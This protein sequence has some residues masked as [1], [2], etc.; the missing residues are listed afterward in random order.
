MGIPTLTRLGN[1]AV[2]GIVGFLPWTLPLLPALPIAWRARRDPAVRYALASS[3]VPLIVVFL[4][5]NQRRRYLRPVSR[6]LAVRGG[7]WSPPRT[8]AGPPAR[9][10]SAWAPPG[11][12]ARGG[13]VPRGR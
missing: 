10:V 9:R 5:E 6:A 1:S 8:G 13:A 12:A 2:D 11:P 3:I 7:W 4:A